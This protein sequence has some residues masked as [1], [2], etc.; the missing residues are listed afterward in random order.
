[1]VVTLATLT[2]LAS[3]VVAG[4]GV[5]SAS[6]LNGVATTANPS[7]QAYLASGGSNTE[8]TITLPANAACDGDTATHGYHVWSYLVKAGT[9]VDT[10]T[11]NENTGPSQGLGL[12][13][14]TATYYGPANTAIDTGQIIGIPNDLEWGPVVSDDSLLSTLLYKSKKSGAW[15]GGLA[16]AN[17]AGDVTDYWNTQITFTKSTTD[18]KGFVWS[19]V[20]GGL[21]ITTSTLPAVTEG[22]PYSATLSAAGG[23]TPYTWKVTGLPKGLKAKGDLISGTVKTT[24]AAKGYPLTVTLS[25][26]SKP[27]QSA[28]KSI[29]L[30][31]NA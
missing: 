30:T 22:T 3:L 13:D 29:T 7:N 20:P 25:D 17:S 6:T 23:V 5:A 27:K 1:V 21:T 8:Y 10:L 16:C 2:A 11:F 15:D 14:S 4:M 24:V 31:V 26:K 28:T 12:F 18:P 19:A 9:N